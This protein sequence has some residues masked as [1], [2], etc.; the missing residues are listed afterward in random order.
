MATRLAGPFNSG[1]AAGGAGVATNDTDTTVT[2]SGLIVGVYVR[3]N[4][5]PPA[6]TTDV[7]I[8]TTGSS[9]PA[10]TILAITD[11]ATDGWFYPRV[12]I[13]DTSGSAQAT[14]WD[15][16]PIDDI[17]NVKIEQANNSDSIDVWFMLENS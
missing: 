1:V 4:D 11:A 8:A 7:T 13:H 17:V 14:V 15:Y 9:F 6:G 3:Y 16:I 2:L 5:A 12:N 10:T